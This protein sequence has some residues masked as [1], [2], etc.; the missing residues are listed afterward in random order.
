MIII[1]H[2]KSKKYYKHYADT[3]CEYTLVNHTFCTNCSRYAWIRP[4]WVYLIVL[5]YKVY[6][7]RRR[8]HCRMQFGSNFLSGLTSARKTNRVGTFSAVFYRFSLTST[9]SCSRKQKPALRLFFICKRLKM[10]R[11]YSNYLTVSITTNACECS[12]ETRG[13]FGH[14]ICKAPAWITL[15]QCSLV[16]S[17]LSEFRKKRKKKLEKLLDD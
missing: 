5:K 13:C 7:V 9:G 10:T 15:S 11:I 12:W 3:V 1:I 2:L 6:H 17:H 4:Y 16:A 14:I 8:M